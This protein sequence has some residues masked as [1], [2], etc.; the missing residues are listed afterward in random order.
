MADY[1]GDSRGVTV[2]QFTDAIK[3]LL[4][5][6]KTDLDMWDTS[7]IHIGSDEPEKPEKYAL[8][9]DTSGVSVILKYRMLIGSTYKYLPISMGGTDGGATENSA[10]LNVVRA[11]D[12]TSDIV[13]YGSDCNVS[14]T[15]TSLED[16]MWSTGNGRMYI[17]VNNVCKY[18]GDVEQGTV[19][20]NIKSFLSLGSNLI[21]VVV[22]DAY[23]NIN[24]G[25]KEKN[26]SPIYFQVQC[27]NISLKGQ[28][29]YYYIYE[30]DI[31]FNYVPK[32]MSYISVMK[33]KI[34]GVE[35]DFNEG[36][37]THTSEESR[38]I[39]IP[40]SYLLGGH[41]SHTIEAWFE[42]TVP[43]ETI[44]DGEVIVENRIVSSTHIF[45]EFIFKENG[46]K[47]A[48]IA[49]P[50]NIE[51]ANQFDIFDIHY[52]IYA[53][54]SVAEK[55]GEH[56]GKFKVILSDNHGFSKEEYVEKG[57]D[58]S[59]KYQAKYPN[60]LLLSITVDGVSKKFNPI[61]II[62]DPSSKV[63][64]SENNLELF[65]SS[66]G[67]SNGDA[68]RNEWYFTDSSNNN[69]IAELHDFNFS[70]NGW[71]TD[72]DDVPVLRI[73]G[74]GFVRI[75]LQIFGTDCRVDGKTIEIDF[76]TRDVADYDEIVFTC[77]DNES[78]RGIRVTA[79]EAILKSSATTLS[80]NYKEDSHIRLSFVIESNVYGNS[81]IL[82]YI[83]GISS[84]IAQYTT[85][86]DE[87]S[88]TFIQIDPQDIIIGAQ[89]YDEEGNVLPNK[90]TVD[91]YNIR[92]YKGA[93]PRTQIVNNWIADTMDPIE[94]S[95]RYKRN[96]IYD[97]L[98]NITVESISGLSTNLP[99]LILETDY[100]PTKKEISP[101]VDDVA[102]NVTARFID[103]LDE[104]KSFICT[105]GA[106]VKVQG[107]SSAGYKR[108]NYKIKFKT[109]ESIDGSSVTSK[110][111]LFKDSIPVNTFC[112]KADV[113]SSEGANNVELVGLFNDICPALPDIRE[114]VGVDK[115]LLGIEGRPIVVFQ[116]TSDGTITFLGKYNFNND[117][118][119]PE[120]FGLDDG[121]ESWEGRENSHP[122]NLWQTTKFDVS[123]GNEWY[124][125]ALEARHPD[126]DEGYF[127]LN[128]FRPLVTW[129][130]STYRANATGNRLSKD[131]IVTST[132]TKKVEYEIDSDGNVITFLDA[133]GVEHN[134][135][136]ISAGDIEF[137]YQTY[138]DIEYTD[139]NDNVTIRT[140]YALPKNEN[141]E[142]IHKITYTHDTPEYRLGKF[143][144][145]FPDHF[146]T[147]AM[148]FHYLFSLVFL[149][150][151]N[152][153]KNTFMTYYDELDRWLN[154]PYDFDTALGIDNLGKFLFYYGYEDIDYLDGDISKPIFNGQDSVLWTNIRDS[155][156]D[157]IAEMYR[158][159]RNFK[160][161]NNEFPFSYEGIV[162]RYRDHQMV[163]GESIFNE[164]AYIKYISAYLEENEPKYLPMLQG[165]K[166]SN[167]EWWLFNRFLYM[168]SKYE[169]FSQSENR[170]LFRFEAKLKPGETEFPEEY[171][172]IEMEPYADIYATAR[173]D[174]VN[175]HAR[176]KK[177]ERVR[178]EIPRSYR[179]GFNNTV[180]VIPFASQLSHIGDLSKYQL[181]VADVSHGVKLQSIKLG[182][183][184]A[185]FRNT[186]LEEVSFGRNALLRYIDCRNCINL[187]T[188]ALSTVD[189][190]QCMSAEEVY[191]TGTSIKGIN[192]PNGGN[193]Q[194]LKLPSTITFLTLR[195]LKYLTDL[196]IET[197]VDGGY[198][199]LTSVTIEN[200]TVDPARLKQILNTIINTR[201][202]ASYAGYLRYSGFTI[203]VESCG[204]VNSDGSITY[205]TNASG[206]VDH[207]GEIT[208]YLEIFSKFRQMSNGIEVDAY[209]NGNLKM[210]TIDGTELYSIINY[211]RTYNKFDD[212]GNKTLRY[213]YLSIIYDKIVTRVVFR[214]EYINGTLGKILY[215]QEVEGGSM[216]GSI[217][218]PKSTPTKA[219]DDIAKYEFIGWSRD[220]IFENYKDILP[221]SG[222]FNG[223]IINLREDLTLTANYKTI[224]KYY[225]TFANTY[226][227]NFTNTTIGTYYEGSKV[228]IPSV[229][230][231]IDDE[232]NEVRYY[233]I[234]WRKYL[235]NDKEFT[236]L[237]QATTETLTKDVKTIT[238]GH[239]DECM[240]IKYMATYT[241]TIMHTIT[242]YDSFGT[243]IYSAVGENDVDRINIPAGPERKFDNYYTYTFV[244]WTT[245]KPNSS[246]DALINTNTTIIQPSTIFSN[247]DIEYYPVYSRVERM[248][249]VRFI[250]DTRTR[251]FTKDDDGYTSGILQTLSGEYSYGDA[252]SKTYTGSIDVNNLGN[253]YLI[254]VFK[255]WIAPYNRTENGK[256]YIDFY[257]KYECYERAYL[258]CTSV[259]ILGDGQHVTFGGDN[260]DDRNVFT[261]SNI[262]TSLN[263]FNNRDITSPSGWIRVDYHLDPAD[264]SITA[265]FVKM[266]KAARFI[267]NEC[268]IDGYAHTMA[269]GL[270]AIFE[271][272]IN[273]LYKYS[274]LSYYE[275]TIAYHNKGWLDEWKAAK[276]GNS[277]S[278]VTDYGKSII[279][280]TMLTYF[281]DYANLTSG[282]IQFIIE[283]Q[284]AKL[285]RLGMRI[286]YTVTNI[287]SSEQ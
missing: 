284:W 84:G 252:I 228:T 134:A 262:N 148:L 4:P 56:S 282:K 166:E 9:A 256:N 65:L 198:K 64:A 220:D 215:E 172:Y 159:L 182:D 59:W 114:A 283:M 78:K 94:R 67:R 201:P 133:D 7:G 34:D 8:W 60:E 100:L 272:H 144:K 29:Q 76:A 216:G 18:D 173:Y 24:D 95:N 104:S 66:E 285:G 89:T 184:S 165:S 168:D 142:E 181:S 209:I 31:Q 217:T 150:I 187:G 177:G 135:I 32:T 35:R 174:S 152:R 5:L 211:S 58:L 141:G 258:Y 246:F 136:D 3:R 196:V 38:S 40:T 39:T 188:G 250:K 239:N 280:D 10:E 127:S 12:W 43:L 106:K 214:D 20:R 268:Y 85:T 55:S 180:V 226:D 53:D 278:N 186:M 194:T 77:W 120:V 213:P 82:V 87:N 117:K 207:R 93:L 276:L 260:V 205:T 41:K 233:H 102:E 271:P 124:E 269:R 46:N 224:Y 62:E 51:T 231:V 86:D 6:S 122:L 206:I 274:A 61:T 75:P 281:E 131:Y 72:D 157:E 26:G 92:V 98:G 190:S 179:K 263:S 279:S 248:Y 218:Y 210:E 221:E 105:A 241:P 267:R 110:Y 19:T 199:D 17:Y 191:F 37:F 109:F 247:I 200:T 108:K 1:T 48:V 50:F 286:G 25:S 81:F 249:T 193:I 251:Q 132:D 69:I 129:V 195:N 183:E 63:K 245:V 167:R 234:G 52:A 90:C 225:I 121:D 143:K 155:F 235:Y 162:K 244:G 147:S 71:V 74:N 14:V 275:N 44:V 123:P 236:S 54:D 169:L 103:P 273:L 265:Q 178:V 138:N 212:S 257:M 229:R 145:E 146:M 30:N 243:I 68:N 170:L 287:H 156:S 80:A 45:Y 97:D 261:T 83:N 160:D 115:M 223:N 230:S 23:G 13:T 222:L 112:F 11:S 153:A 163:W 238:M 240:Y 111:S 126:L 151:D 197:D 189:I 203:L 208:N 107:T 270:G 277:T 21:K 28:F 99:Y 119:T 264:A 125:T 57:K 22:R 253:D 47:T 237:K 154:L 139:V 118:G 161:E 255:G 254:F 242:F 16:G 15:W 137:E 96:L 227:D 232:E 73:S 70:S 202:T 259:S 158:T 116:Q 171:M 149:L 27:L 176:A 49:S 266:A 164:D 101:G 113:A 79:Q 42:A 192:L 88:D 128:K 219:T 140:F 36:E 2:A 185:D 130:Y 91:I 175:R 204:L 33:Y